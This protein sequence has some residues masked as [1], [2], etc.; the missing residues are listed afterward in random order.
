MEMRNFFY[1]FSFFYLLS[2]CQTVDLEKSI[3]SIA[4]TVESISDTEQFLVEEILKENDIAQSVII[5]EPPEVREVSIDDI[6]NS[7]K[8]LIGGDALKQ[9]LVDVTILPEYENGR[10][11]GWI[12]KKDFVY[13]VQCQTYHSTMIQFEPGEEMLEMPYISEL[14]VWRIA[15]GVG[16]EK[17]MPQQHLII[18]PDFPSLTSTLIVITNRRVYHMELKSYRDRYMPVVKW[19]YPQGI[20]DNE[21]WKQYESKKLTATFTGVNP[22]FLS[23][24][25]K[26]THSVLKKPVWL[27][28]QVYD[29]GSKTYIILNEQ[30]LHMDY[31]LIFN[32]RNEILNYRTE[33]NI[34]FIDQLIEKVTLRLGKQKVTIQKKK[35]I[36]TD[37]EEDKELKQKE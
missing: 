17:G 37:T 28:K 16:I 33:K 5:V 19:I 26:M 22:E 31:P 10:L 27:P 20:I 35:T 36:I 2:S 6:D 7:R 12:Y 14:D 34:I 25:Y 18:K 23:F 24:D 30:S 11:K 15:R 13:Q 3:K 4:T 1:I 21:T 32:E 8:N 9:H 29:D